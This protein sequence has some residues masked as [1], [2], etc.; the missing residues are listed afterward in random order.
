MKRMPGVRLIA[1]STVVAAVAALA[2]VAASGAAAGQVFRATSHE[3]DS[4]VLSDF[5][6]VPGLTVEQAFVIDIRQPAPFLGER[7]DELRSWDYIKL[8]TVQVDRLLKWYRQGLICIG[9]AAHAM[10]PV[11]GVG[12]NLAIQD[13]VAAANFL[14][15]V[16]LENRTVP[17]STLEKIQQRRELPTRVVQ[18]VQLLI[19]N[20]IIR[21]VLGNNRRMS[22]PLLIRIL[23]AVP[24]LRRIPARLV[25]LG[26]RREHVLTRPG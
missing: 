1:V 25:G 2:G 10:S 3:Q 9:D 13:A 21:R 6:G 19:Q 18:R 26:F 17:E 22:P 23:G 14:V 11:A 24:L 16:L 20:G 12:I 8:R 5:C 15:P 4:I 7:A